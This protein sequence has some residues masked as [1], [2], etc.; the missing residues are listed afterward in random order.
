MNFLIY[1]NKESDTK[2][3]KMSGEQKKIKILMYDNFPFGG[4]SANLIRYFALAVAR[5]GN[6]VEVVLP[7]GNFFGKKVDVNS[8]RNGN[9]ENVRYKHLC[10]IH[11]PRNYFGKVLDI[12]CGLTLPVIYLCKESV[13]K[14]VDKI[15]LYDTYFT[16]TLISLFIKIILRKK[17]IL[18]L[19]EY[20]E[21]PK[22]KFLS[23]P[24]LQWYNFYLGLKLLAK[25]ADG[26]IVASNFLENYIQN[27]L[28]LNKEILVLPNLMDPDIF[29]LPGC[30]PFI[31]NKVTIGYAGTPTR[32][33][34]VMDLIESF[35]I[36]HKKYPNTHLLI[37]GDEKGGY[38]LIPQLEKYASQFGVNDNIT[39]TG[40]V[41]FTRIPE[42]LNSCQILALTRPS[43]VF[44]EAGF[45]TKLGEYFA[46]R[47][48]VVITRV[49]DIPAYFKNKEHVIIVTPEDIN[50]I[51]S[52]FESLLIDDELSEKLCTNAYNWMDRNLNYRNMSVSLCRFIERV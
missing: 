30:K 23:F 15:I 43:G 18:I 20:Y 5:E 25:Y 49:G 50:D 39:F 32:K 47:K 46:C 22:S 52:G 38:S 1:F 33:D 42:L 17:L 8:T 28:K 35:G 24:L 13:K 45:P 9:I 29:H 34:G 2:Q 10:F 31:S 19:P 11:H 26:F 21:K 40:L 41:S 27:T 16:T 6:D 7:T 51:V 3:E 12:I 14:N 44:A 4:A 36:L 37:I 48:P